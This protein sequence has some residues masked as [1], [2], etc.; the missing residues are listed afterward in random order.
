M[1]CA[2]GSILAEARQSCPPMSLLVRKFPVIHDNKNVE[3]IPGLNL[4]IVRNHLEDSSCLPVGGLLASYGF[5]E[6]FEEDGLDALQLLLV[7]L[8][9]IV[10]QLLHVEKRTARGA[11][12]KGDICL[13]PIS[14][15]GQ[16]SEGGSDSNG[17]R[18]N[19]VR[20]ASRCLRRVQRQSKWPLGL[21]TCAGSRPRKE[22]SAIATIK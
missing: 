9:Q 3:T 15:V 12:V 7:S 11:T 14:A 2:D 8:G 5:V 16:P 1:D 13:Q 10:D 18:F 22:L 20:A 6:F 17:D 21:R 19:C 4:V